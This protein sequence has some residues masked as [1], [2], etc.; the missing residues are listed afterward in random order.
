MDFLGIVREY[1]AEIVDM[2]DRLYK[3]I[4]NAAL[5]E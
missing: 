5:G 4:K 2:F 3:L 1:W